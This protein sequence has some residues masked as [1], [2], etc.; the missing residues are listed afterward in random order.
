MKLKKFLIGVAIGISSLISLQAS[1]VND[2]NSI[3]QHNLCYKKRL[4]PIGHYDLAL[5]TMRD[6]FT[7]SNIHIKH[8]DKYTITGVGDWVAGE[9]MYN[10]TITVVFKDKG[11]VVEINTNASYSIMKKEYDTDTGGIAGI[12]FPMPVLWKKSFQLKSTGNIIDPE[13]YRG[14]YLNFQK[15]FVYNMVHNTK[16]KIADL[17]IKTKP[18]IVVSTKNNNTET[19]QSETNNTTAVDSNTTGRG[20]TE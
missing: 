8:E 13:F 9:T 1:G 4:L 3:A 14:F 10:M 16:I 5:A 6:L 2:F 20:T 7:N 19:N 17:D 18:K 11:D 12:N 15:L